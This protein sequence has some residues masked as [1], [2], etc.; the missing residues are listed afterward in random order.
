MG[1]LLMAAGVVVVYR[2]LF[3]RHDDDHITADVMTTGS[4]MFLIGVVLF[5]IGAVL[6]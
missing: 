5:V 2:G 6:A 3:T 4:W 1:W